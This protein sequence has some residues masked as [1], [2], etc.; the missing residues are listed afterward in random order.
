MEFKKSNE[1]NKNKEPKNTYQ[2][3]TKTNTEQQP[4]EASLARVL[5]GPEQVAFTPRPA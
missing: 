1:I 4:Y 2:R 3:T 5:H